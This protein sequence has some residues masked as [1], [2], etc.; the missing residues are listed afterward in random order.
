[1]TLDATLQAEVQQ[2]ITGSFEKDLEKKATEAL[3]RLQARWKMTDAEL[4]TLYSTNF[5]KLLQGDV[6]TIDV[7][8]QKGAKIDQ[9]TNKLFAIQLSKP[10]EV[11]WWFF[12]NRA[13][14][15]CFEQVG[16]NQD[17]NKNSTTENIMKGVIDEIVALP[18]MMEQVISHPIDF[19]TWLS[20][21]FKG[22][23]WK[24]LRAEISNVWLATPQ[25]QYQSGR[26]GMMAVMMIFPWAIGKSLLNIG[27]KLGKVVKRTGERILPNA[28]KRIATT[29]EKTTV[30]GTINAWK[31]MVKNSAKK[32]QQ[33]FAKTP[34]QIA[35]KEAATAEKAVLKNEK[36]A[37]KNLTKTTVEESITK[38]KNLWT[39]IEIK[40]KDIS[41]FKDKIKT[42]KT[43]ME[44]SIDPNII[45]KLEKKI[46]EAKKAQDEIM[47][48]I[49]TLRKAQS[50]IKASLPT[51]ALAKDAIGNWLNATKDVLKDW[52]NTTKNITKKSYERTKNSALW[53][54]AIR[55]G[56]KSA[57]GI[58]RL[59]RKSINIG[60]WVIL[61]L[62]KVTNKLP[63]L[64]NISKVRSLKKQ[65]QE[66]KIRLGNLEKIWLKNTMIEN[67]KNSIKKA[68]D[69]LIIAKLWLRNALV[70]SGA[71][72]LTDANNAINYLESNI[73]DEYLVIDNNQFI[74]N[75]N[76]VATWLESWSTNINNLD[77]SSLD[78][79]SDIELQSTKITLTGLASKTWS[80]ETNV[81]IASERARNAQ[82]ELLKK[83]PSLTPANITLKYDIQPATSTDNVSQRQGA[84]IKT[85]T[86]NLAYVAEYDN[87]K[88]NQTMIA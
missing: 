55:L 43:E 84:K 34:E 18:E 30:K 35:K 26:S 9:V 71:I 39:E 67:V 68:N 57:E 25:Q 54:D 50:T 19:I 15:R 62:E 22:E 73:P 76:N 58:K 45:K 13:K 17:V 14:N 49:T 56:T 4:K 53:K 11:E 60:K 40:L 87:I 29:I 38:F 74:N 2:D 82:K 80:H 3:N 46:Q 41:H 78:W 28:T 7:L 1:M 86:K 32:V 52:F 6:K 69:D 27:K 79:L 37:A 16:I 51:W 42:F 64:K 48:E 33:K 44:S 23:T 20:A 21:L 61:K 5:K 36:I 81:K 70:G 10:K 63:L 85:E 77:T 88:N 75:E 12:I 83:Y 65:L 59:S 31:D 72:A 66:L 8:M 47:W 24:K